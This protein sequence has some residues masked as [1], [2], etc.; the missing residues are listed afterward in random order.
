MEGKKVSDTEI[1]KILVRALPKGKSCEWYSALMDYG[2]FLKKSGIKLN[3]KHEN[4][5]KQ[6]KFAG[7]NREARGAILRALASQGDSS[8]RGVPLRELLNLLGPSRRAQLRMALHAL[9]TEGLIVKNERNY[10][11]A[12]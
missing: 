6:K 12:N 10:T 9:Q 8:L 1:E 11:L 4:Y 5:V 3:A 7:S 2:A